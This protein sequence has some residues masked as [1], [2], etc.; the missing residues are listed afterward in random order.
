M[1]G[2]M[3]AEYENWWEAHIHARTEDWIVWCVGRCRSEVWLR[4]LREIRT[5]DVA[6]GVQY[7]EAGSGFPA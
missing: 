7:G 2:V 3:V 6:I 4:T 5:M 1:I